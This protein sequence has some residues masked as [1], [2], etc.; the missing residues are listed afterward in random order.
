MIADKFDLKIVWTVGYFKNLH[1][2]CYKKITTLTFKYSEII[3]RAK[4]VAMFQF[5][6]QA[7]KINTGGQ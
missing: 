3:L 2:E 1:V 7:N 5:Q 6:M 4:A